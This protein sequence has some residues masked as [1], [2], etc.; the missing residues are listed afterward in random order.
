[1]ITYTDNTT[2]TSYGISSTLDSLMVGGRN[3][4]KHSSLVGEQLVC[5]DISGCNSVGTMKYENS[6]YHLVTPN[7]GNSNNGILFVFKDFTT[8]GLKKGDTITFSID[9]KGTSDEHNPFL[10]IWLPKEKIDVWWE[11]T[12]SNMA[13][14]VPTKEFKRAWTNDLNGKWYGK[15]FF[16]TQYRMY[17][18]VSNNI[19]GHDWQ[20]QY[21]KI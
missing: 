17:T 14:F 1:M 20:W 6:G 8:L 12:S 3:L 7:A 11:G 16:K 13:E 4:F 2:S 21:R 18:N 5:D 15:W 10:K 19:S 9:V